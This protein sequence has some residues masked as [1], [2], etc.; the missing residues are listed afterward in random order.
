MGVT[1]SQREVERYVRLE[2][3]RVRC[4]VCPRTCVVPPGERGVC[5]VRE[6]RDGRFELLT[7]GRA[8]STAIDPIEKKPLFHFAPGARVLS[9]AARGCNFQ[10]DFCQNYRIAV[11]HEG[12]SEQSLPPAELVNSARTSD[13]DGIAY[14]YTEPTIFL[15]YALDTMDET[16]D[17]MYNVFVS[18]GYMT[19]D[20]AAQLAS[21]LDAINVDI[22]GDKAFYRKYCGVPDPSPI[23]EAV[24]TL[25]EA[26]VHVEITN[27]ILPDEND[28]S[29]VV[30]ERMA[31]IRDTL[32]PDTPVHFSRFHPA[33]E[34]QDVPPTPVDRLESLMDVAREEGLHHVYCGNVTGHEAESTYCPDCGTCVI[35]RQ[36]YQI[37]SYDLDDGC[38]PSC[39]RRINIAGRQWARGTASSGQRRRLFF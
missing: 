35:K 3:D 7:Y 10:C 14:T 18:N 12:R 26:G 13:C 27:L 9:I 36:G 8:V 21:N 32:G 2:D 33:Y 16:G 1:N 34:M 24:K 19:T 25:A 30:R 5:R 28:D 29:D 22:K 39:G 11:E 31:W 23:Y 15:E 37:R 17:D 4:D 20:T 6:N 38:C